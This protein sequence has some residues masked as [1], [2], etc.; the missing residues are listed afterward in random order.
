VSERAHGECQTRCRLYKRADQTF[1]LASRLQS[2]LNRISKLV[3]FYNVIDFQGRPNWLLRVGSAATFGL[4]SLHTLST[5][6]VWGDESERYALDRRAVV[7]PIS[8]TLG[9]LVCGQFLDMCSWNHLC[10]LRL[11]YVSLGLDM[12]LAYG[13]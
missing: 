4:T 10:A 7:Q 11:R 3:L 8:S 6:H 2:V 12:V 9:S 1:A 13:L 5:G